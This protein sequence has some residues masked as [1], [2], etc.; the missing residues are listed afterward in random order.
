[1]KKIGVLPVKRNQCTIK[2]SI[3]WGRNKI[4]VMQG[5]KF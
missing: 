5:T 1:M 3:N 2:K 4:L